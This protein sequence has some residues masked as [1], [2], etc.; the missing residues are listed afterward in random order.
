MLEDWAGVLQG[1]IDG[2]VDPHL[3]RGL[4]D[5]KFIKSMNKVVILATKARETSDIANKPSGYIDAADG[6][7]RMISDIIRRSAEGQQ[8]Y[9]DLHENAALV[10][11]TLDRLKNKTNPESKV[12]LSVSDFGYL[13]PI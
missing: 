6:V 9:G 13:G 4:F 3:R 5:P 2:R 1:V 8:G 10:F 11:E 7:D 12:S